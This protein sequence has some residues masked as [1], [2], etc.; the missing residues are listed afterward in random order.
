MG[1]DRGDC[2]PFDFLNQME[3]HLTQNR[4]ENCHHYHILFDLKGNEMLKIAQL[5]VEGSTTSFITEHGAEGFKEALHYTE[6]S[7]LLKRLMIKISV[8]KLDTK[9]TALGCFT[10]GQFAVL[11]KKT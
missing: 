4:K 8:G 2:F 10:V 7:K 11:K 3:Q 6:R 1:Y 5:R 9:R